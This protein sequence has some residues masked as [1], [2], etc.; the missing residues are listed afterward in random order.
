MSLH[1]IVNIKALHVDN[2]WKKIPCLVIL[3]DTPFIYQPS[4]LYIK[5]LA[6][7]KKVSYSMLQKTVKSIGYFY[8]YFHII[9][10]G[11]AKDIYDVRN[12]VEEFLQARV[13]GSVL[14]WKPVK[15]QT[16]NIDLQN[17]SS[18][19]HWMSLY[20]DSIE[21]LNPRKGSKISPFKQKY[22][23][24]INLKRDMLAHISK[25]PE[26]EKVIKSLKTFKGQKVPKAF[27]VDKIF[28]LISNTT[29][30]RDKIAFLL[31]A[32][33]GRR[34]SE[35]M[36]LFVSDISINTDQELMAII[37][38]PSDSKFQW[39]DKNGK[40]ITKTRKDYLSSNFGIKPRTELI[41][42]SSYCGWK[43]MM[44]D[45]ET[46]GIAYLYI[47]GEIKNY[48]KRLHIEYMK[49]RMKFNHHPYYFVK[50]NGD[51]LSINNLRKSF[52]RTCK[53][54]GI[55]TEYYK[56]DHGIGLH[57]LRHFYGYYCVNILKL[58]IPFVQRAMGH[59]S[60]DSTLHYSRAS[61]SDANKVIKIKTI[62]AK[63]ENNELNQVER[64]DLKNQL[65]ELNEDKYQIK[66][67]SWMIDIKEI[68]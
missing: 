68:E 6:S 30:T 34:V 4:L 23:R 16:A 43:G 18:F 33:G 26:N 55:D 36:Q 3:E 10:K 64:D 25:L 7:N 50:K 41:G 5:Y 59:V 65:K 40:L 9:K 19:F 39:T 49:E 12:S 2:E 24:E 28:E 61:I 48:L 44:F 46:Q 11:K 52:Y 51:P 8:D 22:L 56:S 62:E 17:I 31:L 67:P 13:K 35:I 37:A 38:H 58:E 63:L 27:P 45:D 32:F 54:I 42:E 47:I 29:N 60:Q 57:G 53:K 66:I 15:A 14:D 1:T 21:D 20:E